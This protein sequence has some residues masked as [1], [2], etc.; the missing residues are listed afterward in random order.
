MLDTKPSTHLNVQRQEAKENKYKHVSHIFDIQLSD[1]MLTQEQESVL[2][3][4]MANP[5]GLHVLTKTPGNG[6]SFFIKYIIP[7]LSVKGKTVLLSETMGAASRRLSRLANTVHTTFRIPTRGYLYCLSKSSKV[8][9]K[10]KTSNVIII[11]KVSM[12][13]SYMLFAIEQ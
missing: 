12:M 7:Y 13:T 4:I 1:M 3:A 5:K 11:N 2:D 9:N 8:L 10:M 6:K